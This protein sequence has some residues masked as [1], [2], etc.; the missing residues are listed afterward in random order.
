MSVSVCLC[1]CVSVCVYYG[2]YIYICIYILYIYYIYEKARHKRKG[3][4]KTMCSMWFT[5]VIKRLS[6]SKRVHIPVVRGVGVT[7]FEALETPVIFLLAQHKC[8]ACW[9]KMLFTHIH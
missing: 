1:V 9:L 6:G 4:C 3:Q 2:L 8:L 7:V 5:T